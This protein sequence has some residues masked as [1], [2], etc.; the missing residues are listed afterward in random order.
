[1]ASSQK[2]RSSGKGTVQAKW[3]V[4]SAAEALASR[5]FE[6]IVV[7]DKAA[8]LEEIKTIIPKGASVMN[9]ASITLREIG[10]MDHLAT[11][12]HGWN[13]LHA[14]IL[15]EKDPSKIA[16]HRQKALFADYYLGSVHALTLEGEML[17]A[18]NSG[19]QLPHLAF[20]SPNCILVVGEQKIVKDLAAAWKRLNEE[21]IPLEDKRALGDYGAHTMDTKTLIMHRMNPTSGRSVK[22]ILV[23]DKLGF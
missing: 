3:S 4:G 1:M 19:S 6:A 21:V 9:G 20:T 11:A 12:K 2:S 8:A 15:A 10:Y 16:S 13:D 5:G 18:S 23:Q 14:N 7:A 22:V 17:I